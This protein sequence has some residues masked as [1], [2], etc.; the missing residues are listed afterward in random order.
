MA[1]VDLRRAGVGLFAAAGPEASA[2]DEDDERRGLLGVS[3]PEVD[4]LLLAVAVGEAFVE[5][6]AQAMPPTSNIA[7]VEIGR[8]GAMT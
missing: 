2:V 8:M 6:L 1:Q 5:L 4:L 3:D 7:M